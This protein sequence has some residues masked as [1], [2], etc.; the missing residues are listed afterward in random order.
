MRISFS[1]SG[2]VAYF[3]GLNK[4]NTIEVDALPEGDQKEL[5]QLVDASEFF[6]LPEGRHPARALRGM[7]HY[8]LTISEGDRERTV[9]VPAPVESGPLQGLMQCVRRHVSG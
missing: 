8:T 9:C 2:G 3:P 1:E 5:R 7:Q 4:P 6:A